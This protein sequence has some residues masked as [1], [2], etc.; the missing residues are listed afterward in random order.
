MTFNNQT[1]VAS[2]ELIESVTDPEVGLATVAG[3]PLAWYDN[4][5]G[6]IGDI[7]NAQQGT[8]VGSDSLTYV[9]QK[10]WSNALGG[11]TVARVNGNDYS[12]SLAPPAKSITGGN[13]STFTVTTGLTSGSVSAIALAVSGLPAGVSGAFV[14]STVAAGSSSTLTLTATGAVAPSSE[15]IVVSGSSTAGPHTAS[16]YLTVFP[17]PTPTPTVTATPTVSPTPTPTRTPTPTPT[18][19][20]TAPPTATPTPTRTPNPLARNFFNVPPCRLLD[21]RTAVGAYGGPSIAANQDRAFVTTGQCGI[22][23]TAQAVAVNITVTQPT[24][25]GH[26]RFYPGGGVLPPSSTINYS[27]GQT[28]ANNAILT[29]GTA[30][31][32]V[33]H[34]G[35]A[36]GTVQVIVDINGYFQ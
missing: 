34:S 12:I 32:F 27:S 8:I 21:T 35:Q 30:G 26:L 11:C 6:E 14:P 24:S 25:S 2:H 9:V 33:I 16:S 18:P 1:S 22:P 5:N 17:V 13:T 3:P 19:T 29:L 23:I 7:C 31:D 36:T 20:P 4:T 28:R 15:I 10:Q